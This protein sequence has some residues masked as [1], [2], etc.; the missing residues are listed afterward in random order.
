MEEEHTTYLQVPIFMTWPQFKSITYKIKN[1][2]GDSNFDAA[3]GL[4]YRRGNIV[5]LVRIYADIDINK[6]EDIRSRYLKEISRS[7]LNA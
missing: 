6:L 1:N 5:D 7:I 2:M 3:Q 4:F